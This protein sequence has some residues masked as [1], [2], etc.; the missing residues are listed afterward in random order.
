MDH[1]GFAIDE[2]ARIWPRAKGFCEVTFA[3]D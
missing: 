3:G 1:V 2:V